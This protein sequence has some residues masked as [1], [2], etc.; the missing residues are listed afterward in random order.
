[1]GLH[2]HTVP[3]QV[4]ETAP[5]GAKLLLAKFRL[6]TDRTATLNT[7]RAPEVYTLPL[8]LLAV[9]TVNIHSTSLPELGKPAPE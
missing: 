2:C 5:H 7:E 9:G 1:M 6:H 8:L 4:A 3:G